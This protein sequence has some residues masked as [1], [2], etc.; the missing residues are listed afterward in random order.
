[1]QFLLKFT[2]IAITVFWLLRLLA[3]FLFPWAMRKTAEKV[4]RDA[5][6]GRSFQGSA[7]GGQAQ[8]RAYTHQSYQ[9]QQRQRPHQPD[10]KVRIDYVP[11]T[12][13][14]DRKGPQKAGEFVDFEELDG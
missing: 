11:P 14:A 12:R 6:Q 9:K 13:T 10:G 7:F 8:Y 1:M 3:R 2:L 5:Q 4:M